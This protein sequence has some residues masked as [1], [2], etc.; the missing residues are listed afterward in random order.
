MQNPVRL[1]QVY[2]ISRNQ[3]LRMETRTVKN[4]CAPAAVIED[5]IYIIGGY[6]RRMI[7]YDTKANKFVKCSLPYKLFDHGSLALVCVSNRP[8]PP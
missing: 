2:H 7:A 4:V 8:N 3:W 1:I 5:K 6:T